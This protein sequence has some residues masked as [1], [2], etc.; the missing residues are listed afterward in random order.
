M[1]PVIPSCSLPLSTANTP[2]S[3]F[4]VGS[5]LDQIQKVLPAHTAIRS[6][7]SESVVTYLLQDYVA[8][9][10]HI[11]YLKRSYRDNFLITI[12]TRTCLTYFIF[13]VT[14]LLHFLIFNFQ[15][16]VPSFMFSCGRSAPYVLHYWWPQWKGK[17]Y[18]ERTACWPIHCPAGW[19]KLGLNS[20]M[21]K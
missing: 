8:E 10:L 17:D 7:S 15:N 11:I 5:D 18:P 12:Y 16:P 21:M 9:L 3:K 20:L 13:D 19:K 1:S 14:L 6:G 2:L 4:P